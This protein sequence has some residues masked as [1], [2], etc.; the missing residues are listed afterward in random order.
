VD[1]R[2]F[3]QRLVLMGR[4]CE[5]VVI[6]MQPSMQEMNTD[7]VAPNLRVRRIEDAFLIPN[8]VLKLLN[9]G[10]ARGGN[11]LI[12]LPRDGPKNHQ[13]IVS[14]IYIPVIRQVIGCS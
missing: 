12:P 11:L 13:V 6:E 7:R 3:T 1:E 5:A 10:L 14:R 8:E 2:R 9:L 4:T